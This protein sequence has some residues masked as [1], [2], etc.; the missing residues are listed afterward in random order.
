MNTIKEHIE[1]FREYNNCHTKEDG[2]FSDCEDAGSYSNEPDAPRDKS[3]GIGQGERTGRNWKQNP[4]RCGR[5][6]GNKGKSKIRC[7]D[8]K[9]LWEKQSRDWDNMLS[10]EQIRYAL[11]KE[12]EAH[13]NSRSHLNSEGDVVRGTLKLIEG[14]ECKSWGDFLKQLNLMML[15]AKGEVGKADR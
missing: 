5:G 2:K 12:L 6:K 7:H 4:K 8:N 13:L 11:V 1:K 3:K 14:G 10:D 9:E 15:A